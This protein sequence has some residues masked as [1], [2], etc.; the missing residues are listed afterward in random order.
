MSNDQEFRIFVVDRMD[1]YVARRHVPKGKKLVL[2]VEHDEP[3]HHRYKNRSYIPHHEHLAYFAKRVTEGDFDLIIVGNNEGSG[4]KR[5]RALPSALLTKV[6]VV[7]N[8][9]VNMGENRR[10]YEALGVTR[11]GTR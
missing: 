4:V 10:E 9:E 5:V 11:F 2:E 3:Y 7:W 1:D 6:L 8:N